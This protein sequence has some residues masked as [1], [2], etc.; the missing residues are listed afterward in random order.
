MVV[1]KPIQNATGS[2]PGFRKVG[3]NVV[4]GIDPGLRVTGYG[5][6][7]CTGSRFSLVEG[8]VIEGGGSAVSMAVRLRQLFEGLSALLTEFR[9]E[10][11]AMEQL[12]SHYAHPRTAILMAHARGVL[13]LAAAIS[14]VEV[15][16]YSATEVKSSLT[17]NGRATKEQMQTAIRYTLH[18]DQTPEPAD[19]ADALA[20][21]LCHVHRMAD[22]RPG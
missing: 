21:A 20:V 1:E 8:G 12:Y 18:L 13:T 9:P 15:I 19:V 3:E 10:A 22:R 6:I 5:L 16:D 14:D 17:G 7:S 2:L 4:L 11:M